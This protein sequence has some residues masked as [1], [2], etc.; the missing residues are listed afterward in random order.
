MGGNDHEDAGEVRV[1]NE[2]R[3]RLACASAS[4]V[5]EQFT[6]MDLQCPIVSLILGIKHSIINTRNKTELCDKN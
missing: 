3:Q 4:E 6:S 5:C 2:K 1:L